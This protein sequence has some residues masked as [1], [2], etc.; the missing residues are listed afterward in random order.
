MDKILNRKLFRQKALDTYGTKIVI[1]AAVGKLATG[2]GGILSVSQEQLAEKNKKL[3]DFTNTKKP[4]RTGNETFLGF[5]GKDSAVSA[6][7][8][9]LNILLP[10]AAQLMTGTVRPGQSRLSGL[11]ESTGKGLASVGPTILAMKELDLKK[12][13]EDREAA[14]TTKS[15]IET[16]SVRLNFDIPGVGKKG[17]EKLLLKSDIAAYNNYFK[18]KGQVPFS[19]DRPI[20][21]ILKE[22]ELKNQ[23]EIQKK[24]KELIT[25][26]LVRNNYAF[27][28]T[29]DLIGKIE[30]GART[31][32]VGETMETVA[33]ALGVFRGFTDRFGN[34]FNDQ[35][36]R[37][38]QTMQPDVL[39]VLQS[40]KKMTEEEAIEALKGIKDVDGR[41]I[42]ASIL[43]DKTL[44]QN[45]AQL[46]GA[47]R[48]NLIELGYAI[49]K[50]RE[51]GGRFSV[52]DIE[53]ALRSIGDTS[54]KGV[55]LAKLR[56]TQ[57]IIAARVRD[58]YFATTYYSGR[59]SENLA[60]FDPR[61]ARYHDYL[62]GKKI[63]DKGETVDDSDDFMTDAE[64]KKGKK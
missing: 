35:V 61:Y 39:G 24:D 63:G 4:K 38:K 25:D 47:A 30:R 9:R 44:I 22:Q 27:S 54:N 32:V 59:T 13:K 58:T 51:E 55:A 34:K 45:F 50:S 40:D 21:E 3:E 31:G 12:R 28:L 56:E 7:Q 5:G 15:S 53:L 52:T 20:D 48:A 64:M 43:N 14:A 8:A 23:L 49:A 29:G 26:T 18:D 1:K 42:S 62:I 36:R 10:I 57:R 11:L 6:D 19:V 46:D 17:E 2:G 33:G 16:K 41:T 37:Y 60:K